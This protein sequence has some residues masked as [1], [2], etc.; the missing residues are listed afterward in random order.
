MISKEQLQVHVALHIVSTI[1]KERETNAGAQLEFSF[2]SDQDH[3]RLGL[4]P[5]LA[6]P[7]N[8]LKEIPRAVSPTASQSC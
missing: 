6:T 5:S 3:L 8:S 7:G 1:R 4:S 2:S